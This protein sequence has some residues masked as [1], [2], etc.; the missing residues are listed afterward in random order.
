MPET[1]AHAVGEISNLCECGDCEYV[2]TDCAHIVPACDTR[3][4]ASEDRITL[5]GEWT[6]CGKAAE[7]QTQAAREEDTERVC[8]DCGY[9]LIDDPDVVIEYGPACGDCGG[10]AES[11]V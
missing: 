3:T 6:D 1:Q 2:A 8:T 9:P 11:M 7:Q 5:C 10:P 4:D